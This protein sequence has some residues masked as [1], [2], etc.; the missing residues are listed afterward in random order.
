MGGFEDAHTQMFGKPTDPQMIPPPRRGLLKTKKIVPW[1]RCLAKTRAKPFFRASPC[2]A[3]HFLDQVPREES[4][5]TPLPNA[6]I[7]PLS[8]RVD[9]AEMSK[10]V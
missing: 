5:S 7:S 10:Q 3:R 2:T 8:E 9:V 1:D 4:P 6:L